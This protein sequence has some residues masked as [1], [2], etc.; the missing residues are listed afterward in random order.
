MAD[1]RV[2]DLRALDRDVARAASSIE[3]WR[4]RVL[5]DP[6]GAADEPDPFEGLRHVAAKS[7]R[8]AL[9]ELPVSAADVQLR[10]ALVRWIEVL[11]QT[12]IG[13][14]DQV[15]WSR[16]ANDRAARYE[17][18]EPR[19][20]SW[21]EGWREAVASR[22]PAEARRW[23][24]ALAGA[25]P[26]IATANRARVARSLE[27]VRRLGV[28][29]PWDAD[30]RDLG[31]RARV[32]AAAARLLE[33]TEDLARAHRKETVKGDLDAAS[34]LHAAIAR[35]AGDGWPSRLT[36]R[37]FEDVFG[38]GPRALPI[39]LGAL[40]RVL[41]AASFARGLAAFGRAVRAAAA[42]RALPFAIAR[43]P[44]RAGEHRLGYAFGALATDPEFY[45]RA[46]GTG[47][48]NAAGQ[49]R[50]LAG[51][52]LL[53][54]RLQAARVLLGDEDAFAPRDLFDELTTRAFG[55]ALEPAFVGAWPAPRA[56]DAERLVALFEARALRDTLRD[57]F[58]V[59]WFRN[60]KAW[61]YLR[62]SEA[63]PILVPDARPAAAVGRAEAAA[64]PGAQPVL[65]V[66]G[67]ELQPTLRG[68][69]ET[70][71]ARSADVEGLLRAFE[72]ALG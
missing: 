69:T 25:A 32:R 71:A 72:G 7:T 9:L 10:R 26:A 11:V 38:P 31:G 60:P 5:E 4:A 57:R 42:P 18:D 8:D 45:T 16:A 2:H 68:A 24:R 58:D 29:H 15:E 55:A 33:A 47:R 52:A 34:V 19:M 66:G 3:R 13:L 27:V 50:I 6:E 28:A 41:G 1:P 40:P 62:A 61:D 65:V 21:R 37:W 46:L 48:R 17:G 43:D 36:P 20:A 54:A 23:L 70:S 22:T 51:T 67:A 44:F 30:G 39:R 12:R 56:D 63:P 53:E 35:T 14:A 64:V 59:D 49:A